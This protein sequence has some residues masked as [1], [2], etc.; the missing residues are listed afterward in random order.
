MPQQDY[1]NDRLQGNQDPGPRDPT[2]EDI[3][4]LTGEIRKGW[5]PYVERQRRMVV[6]DFYTIPE[7]AF[8]DLV[9]NQTKEI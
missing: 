3:E 5:S 6:D 8:I 1:R 4:F 7:V 9:L 2:P